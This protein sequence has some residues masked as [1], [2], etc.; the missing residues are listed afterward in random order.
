MEP[1]TTKIIVKADGL[2]IHVERSVSTPIQAAPGKTTAKPRTQAK[3][4]EAKDKPVPKEKPAQ[5]A[6]TATQAK[7]A[8]KE[9]SAAGAKP[10]GS[11][12]QKTATSKTSAA[13]KTTP[14]A[15][16]TANRP[17]QTARRG[18]KLAS[19]S[20]AST[21][22]SPLADFVQLTG[23]WDATCPEL[24][25]LFPLCVGNLRL[26]LCVDNEN[27]KLWGGFSLAYQEGVFLL[28][29]LERAIAGSGI[30]STQIIRYRARDLQG[31]SLAFHG[32]CV[33]RFRIETDGTIGIN[34]R[35]LFPEF[36]EI[37]MT[38]RRRSGPLW[39]GKSEAR[40]Q[41]EWDAFVQETYGRPIGQTGHV[42]V[43]REE[44]EYGGGCEE[45][46]CDHYEDS[47]WDD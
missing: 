2:T 12:L 21:Y 9:R 16:T 3:P 29:H 32:G 35:A 6:K 42:R 7:S 46:D 24:E 22:G 44:E 10:S 23:V 45:E 18:G 41:E 5:T 27:D 39:C 28:D 30:Y 26:F 4:K 8:P 37:F 38:A 14:S 25:R 17:P 20:R 31:G 47:E 33:G 34:F 40:F 13:A 11:D 1:E 19:A 15:G 43:K 36:D